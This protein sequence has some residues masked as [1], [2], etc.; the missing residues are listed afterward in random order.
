MKSAVKRAPAATPGL[1]V[2]PRGVAAVRADA[3]PAT[4]LAEL[5]RT[6][7]E[8]RASNDNRIKE[9]E[10]KMAADPLNEGNVNSINAEITSLKN[11][12]D[13]MNKLIAAARVGGAGNDNQT[14][15][16]TAYN[17][18]FNQWFRRGERALEAGA[19]LHQMAVKALLSTDSDPDGGYVVPTQMAATIDR[20]LGV[21]SAMRGLATVLPISAPTYKKLVNVGGASSGWVAERGTRP[22]TD[23][24]ELRALEFNAMELYA[25]PAITQ[26]A[27][28]DAAMDL[29]AW[30][31][32]EVAVEFAEQEGAAFVTGDGIGKPRGILSYDKVANGSYAYGKVGFVV[33][34]GASDF[35]SSNPTDSLISLTYALK[36]GY[37][38]GAAFLMADGTM[39][40]VRK[41]KDGQ[42]NYIWAPPATAEGVATILGKPTYTDDNMDAVAANAFPIA[43]ANFPRAYLIVDRI[44]VRV[45]RDPYTNK[46]YIHFYTTK[47]VGGGIQLFEAVKLMKIAAS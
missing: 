5:N 7:D 40:K 43:F 42:G 27:L 23:T 38:N 35:A 47:R 31:G 30:L 21:T 19:D 4:I 41:F 9:L 17:R 1:S 33:S 26:T 8:F 11:M 12:M 20:I 32:N 28:D 13:D 37:R 3:N 45:L 39:E 29:G 2:R 36:Q 15:E 44:G 25:N 18:A 24:P 34:G 6:F 22:E 10:K 46:P 14:P 16:R